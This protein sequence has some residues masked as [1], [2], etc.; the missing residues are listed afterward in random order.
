MSRR[1][2]TGLICALLVAATWAVYAQ[3]RHFELV[4]F[5]DL[6]YITDN[7]HVRTGLSPGNVRWAFTHAY[8]GYW[9]PLTWLSYMADRSL[10]DAQSGAY[11]LTSVALHAATACVL[12]LALVRMTRRAWPSAIVTA[13]FAI[14]PMHVESVAWVAERKDVLSGLFFFLTIWAYARYVERPA[15]TRYALVVLSFACGLMAKPIVVTLPL[16]LLLLDV[17]PLKRPRALGDKVP[18]FLLAAAVAAITVITQRQA[19]AV[20]DV[21]AIPVST[22]TTNALVS[23]A[24]YLER[25]FWPSGLAAIYPYPRVA[26]VPQAVLAAVVLLA[27]SVAVFRAR[28]NA[29]YL[30]VGWLWYL[31]TLVPVLGLIQAGPQARADR[32]TYLS[33]TGMAIMVV[34]GI[35]HVTAARRALAR[36]IAAT[37]C[38]ILSIYA[39]LAWQQ[40]QYWRDGETV[41]R[42]ALSVTTGN[43][44]AHTGLAAVLTA[45]GRYTEGIEAYGDAIR[46]APEFPEAYAGLGRVLLA[47]DRAEA[48]VPALTEAVRLVPR[49]AVSQ[50]NL[51]TALA[52]MG[53]LDE[54]NV[55]YREAVRLAPDF[56]TAHSGLAINLATQGRIGE[57]TPHFREVSRLS[58]ESADGHF[59]LGNALAMQGQ[60]DEAIVELTIAARLQPASAD[61]HSNLGIALASRGRFD[62]AI[63]ELREAIKLEPNRQELRTNLAFVMNRRR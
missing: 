37:A 34:W 60:L 28:R 40:A 29:P 32:Y 18:L 31:V 24:W 17:W 38:I 61:I 19:G 39:A 20:P 30:L 26:P 45:Q 42:R 58:P 21:A 3:V 8:D 47:S 4:D 5:D 2:R 50:S 25:I 44:V 12:F 46:A 53:R 43:Y 54:S 6:S 35:A 1:A 41:F 7:P 63:A 23:A 36:P 10:F 49:D 48:A 11:H 14:H 9:M 33:M 56:G 16:V 51:A 15:W 59:Q 62:E 57:A 27:I 22:R 13:L 55:A 52:R